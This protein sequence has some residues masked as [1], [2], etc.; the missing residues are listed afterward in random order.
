MPTY[1]TWSRKANRQI[2]L[3]F[4]NFLNQDAPT[5]RAPREPE[6]LVKQIERF[7]KE[8]NQRE[9]KNGRYHKKICRTVG[10]PRTCEEPPVRPTVQAEEQVVAAEDPKEEEEQATTLEEQG[11]ETPEPAAP[12]LEVTPKKIILLQVI[13]EIKDIKD[14]EVQAIEA[15]LK[16]EDHKANAN[17]VPQSEDQ[18]VNANHTLLTDLPTSKPEPTNLDTPISHEENFDIEVLWP[19]L[20]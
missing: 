5:L 10:P 11:E 19:A 17:N 7:L 1:R 20:L 16:G 15:I 9:R 6:T 13:A 8:F 12:I 14:E 2:K 18:Q 4:R 3:L